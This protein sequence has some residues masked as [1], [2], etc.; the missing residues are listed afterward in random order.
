M[1]V[2]GHVGSDYERLR[3]DF[4]VIP[5]PYR[6][7][8]RVMLVPAIRPDVALI[9]AHLADAAGTLLLEEREDDGLL[10]RASK[11]V[12]ASAERIVPTEEI[13]GA[14]HGV[15][16]ESLH[17][18]AVVELRRGAHP[19]AVRALYGIDEPH[20][21]SYMAAARDDS[22]FKTYLD[23]YVFGAGSHAQYLEALALSSEGSVR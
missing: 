2:P 5:D 18:T 15:T 1:P 21:F 14:R 23:R 10:A 20:L 19:T 3:P 6:P 11:V 22:S 12:I 16:L 8:T 17:V 4:R 9:H 7:G 13:R